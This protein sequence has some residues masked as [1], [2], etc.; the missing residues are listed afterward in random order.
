MPLARYAGQRH[1]VVGMPVANRPRV[2]LE[3]LIGF[4]VNMLPV[5]TDLSGD[6]GFREAA[7]RT[8]RAA[9]EAQ[10][11]Q[12]LPF[13][14][15]V[16][17]IKP[18]RVLGQQAIFQVAL[19][20]QNTPRHPLTFSGLE[21]TPSLVPAI[22][23]RFDL[24]MQFWD[25]GD[26][27]D[28]KLFYDADLFEPG[29][30][31]RMVGHFRSLLASLLTE[32]DRSVWQA[33]MLSETEQHQLL[34]EWNNT[35]VDYPRDKCIHQLVEEQAKRAPAANAL[36][37]QDRRITYETL[38][39][40]AELLAGHLRE[41]G[42]GPDVVVALVMTRCP[43]SV[44]GMLAAWKAG[45]AYLPL[46][47]ANPKERLAHI[48][49][50]VNP[51]VVLTESVLQPRLPSGNWRTVCLDEPLAQLSRKPVAQHCR[52]HHAAYV[53]FTSGSTGQPKGVVV[54]HRNL[55]N[56]IAW[57]N[58]TYGLKPGDRTTQ[59]ASLAFDA[60][61][62][63]IWPALVAGATVCIVDD[64][65]R[66][67]PSLLVKWLVQEQISVSFMPTPLAEAALTE[68]WPA[69]VSLRH[70]LTGGDQLKSRPPASCP[71]K[72]VNHYGPTEA[73]VL[74][75]SAV[76]TPGNQTAGLPP[77]G[78]SGIECLDLYS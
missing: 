2:E 58:R 43:E 76:V 20:V 48:L 63:E 74:A 6:P 28:A 25:R 60:S 14:A 47:P 1:L 61:V 17:H 37:F 73:T 77:I 65:V 21:V 36:S 13:A 40:Q 32:P 52:P 41:M 8:R 45:G 24:E 62:W 46:D 72:L 55:A 5:R 57:H 4:F 56:L 19:V 68:S 78:R 53:I 3:N 42:V 59:L 16:E 31:E 22:A 75:T 29:T 9:L 66:A 34:V 67:D 12:D 69:N 26:T 39:A 23:P 30:I 33:P 27:W 51:P 11:R 35:T 7:A 15:M 54:E 64:E 10:Q 38:N 50:D 70:L 18:D 44:I 49:S 71:F